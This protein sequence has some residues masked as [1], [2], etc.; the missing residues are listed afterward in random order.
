MME[1]INDGGPAFPETSDV[2]WNG[3]TLR[4]Y[5]AGQVIAGLASSDRFMDTTNE[6]TAKIAY[7]QADAMIAQRE[8]K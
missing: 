3:M 4:D 6:H 5:F 1:K 8:G 2:R 7:D